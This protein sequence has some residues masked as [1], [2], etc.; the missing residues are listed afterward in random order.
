V[1][2]VVEGLEGR[3]EEAVE[4][5]RPVKENTFSEARGQG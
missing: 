3:V 4:E 2:V 5:V 1:A